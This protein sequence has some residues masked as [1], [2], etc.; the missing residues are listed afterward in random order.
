M[1]FIEIEVVPAFYDVDP[2]QIVWHGHYI[3]YFEVA[4]SALM[5]SLGY[6]YF[7]MRQSGFLWPIVELQVKY[8]RPAILKQRLTVRAEILEYE[9]RL[10]VAYLISDALTGTKLTKGTTTQVAVSVATNEMQFVCPRI[11]SDKLERL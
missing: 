9:C 8:V 7:E 2:I 10:K 11:L 4:R 5:D 3:K 6:G 1:R